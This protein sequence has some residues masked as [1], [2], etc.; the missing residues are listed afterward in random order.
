MPCNKKRGERSLV[1]QVRIKEK[2]NDAIQIVEIRSG[3][4]KVT[5]GSLMAVGQV[6]AEEE[7]IEDRSHKREKSL[8]KPL[9]AVGQRS[10]ILNPSD[11][12]P[13]GV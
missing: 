8:G 4:V 5:A 2:M 10:E 7:V 13:F 6:T 12:S 1:A 11:A 3:R 9:R